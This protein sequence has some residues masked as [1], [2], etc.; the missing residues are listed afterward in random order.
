MKKSFKVGLL[1]VIS[2]MGLAC[3]TG[4]NKGSSQSSSQDV[5]E[6]VEVSFDTNVISIECYKT[7]RLIAK[8]SGIENYTVN[9]TSSDESIATV[10]ETGLVRAKEKAGVVSINATVNNVTASCS[11]VVTESTDVPVLNLERKALSLE[12]GDTYELSTSIYWGSDDISSEGDISATI[13]EGT[14]VIEVNKNGSSFTIK[15]RTVGYAKVLFKTEVRGYLTAEYL[16]V[17]VLSNSVVFRPSDTTTFKNSEIGYEAEVSCVSYPGYSNSISLSFDAYIGNVKSPAAISYVVKDGSDPDVCALSKVGS[18]YRVRGLKAGV[19]YIEGSFDNGEASGKFTIAIK[20]VKPA[21][22]KDSGLTV[23]VENLVSSGYDL[24]SLNINGASGTVTYLGTQVGTYQDGKMKLVKKNLPRDAASLGDVELTFETE[25]YIY[26]LATKLVTLKIDNKEEF[27]SFANIAINNDDKAQYADG[28]FVLGDNIDYNG[29]FTSMFTAKSFA[30]IGSV[31]NNWYDGTLCGFKG[32]FDGNGFSVNGL[33]VKPLVDTDVYTG[34]IFGVLATGSVIKNI[35]FYNAEVDA[36]TAFLASAGDGTIENIYIQYKTMG[37]NELGRT[38]SNVANSSLRNYCGSFYTYTGGAGINA[39]VKDVIVDAS[40]AR[41]YENDLTDSSGKAIP[42]VYAVSNPN[43]SLSVNALG[44]VNSDYNMARNSALFAGTSYVDA[45]SKEGADAFVNGLSKEYWVVTSTYALFKS[46]VN[47]S[48]DQIVMKANKTTVHAG[49]E[50]ALDLNLPGALVDYTVSETGYGE[51][52]YGHFIVSSN[53]SK[54]SKGVTITATSKLDS[55]NKASVNLD[56]YQSTDIGNVG[57]VYLNESDNAGNLAY[58]SSSYTFNLSNKNVPTSGL[59]G[60]V[61]NNVFYGTGTGVSIN[62]SKQLTIPS[63][64]IGTAYG[65]T[66]IYVRVGSMDYKFNATLVSMVLTT[67]NDVNNFLG[68]AKL[69]EPSDNHLY[70]GYFELG[71]NIEYNFY[72]PTEDGHG[73]KATGATYFDVGGNDSRGNGMGNIL[74]WIDG[75]NVLTYRCDGSDG[76]KGTFDGCGYGINNLELYSAWNFGGFLS[77]MHKDG[78]LKNTAFTNFRPG[79]YPSANKYYGDNMLIAAG[80]G[81]VENVYVTC[82][83]VSFTRPA[84]AL[85]YG[86]NYVARLGNP[87]LKNVIINY[88]NF[89]DLADSELNPH[90]YEYCSNNGMKYIN[91]SACCGF[92]TSN[93]T[94]VN[95]G[96]ASN[97]STII[98]ILTSSGA[99]TGKGGNGMLTNEKITIKDNMTALYSQFGSSFTSSW[100]S[101]WKDGSGVVLS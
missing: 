62:S 98:N 90:N 84:E 44:I 72:D 40:A 23:E 32:V 29:V 47:K 57:K 16:E 21:I 88:E 69:L 73:N 13:E 27:D 87:T 42:S 54:E 78:V 33:R 80:G 76:F 56:V 81:T 19:S 68:V 37:Y 26:S 12:C 96:V 92:D 45:V 77:V 25:Q 83:W 93:G 75:K 66:D 50:V 82:K 6:G 17:E 63:S 97:N 74:N 71:N 65:E 15:G 8:V 7:Y 9:W 39:K 11:V 41:I 101:V 94:F 28:Y 38:S 35:S 20:V 1:T 100:T 46:L 34:G 59:A 99:Y 58:G 10:D 86:K 43:L 79:Y 51:I 2:L 89:N 70:G 85:F 49:E 95:V 67:T 3:M 14:G 24:S 55:T 61:I 52:K 4:C 53:I 36:E 22:K 60:V 64:V 31:A 91:A 18:T 30:S 48:N 5:I